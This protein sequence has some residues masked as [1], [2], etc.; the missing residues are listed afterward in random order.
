MPPGCPLVVTDNAS[1]DSTREILQAAPNTT[2]I[3]NEVGRGF[4]NAANQGLAQ[5]KDCDVV[6]LVNPDAKLRPDCL[7]RLLAAAERYPQAGVYRGTRPLESRSTADFGYAPFTVVRGETVSPT[8]SK[9]L[10]RAERLLLDAAE[11]PSDAEA[12]HA[13]GLFYLNEKQ[14]DKARPCADAIVWRP[15]RSIP[16]KVL[17]RMARSPLLIRWVPASSK[18]TLLP[19]RQRSRAG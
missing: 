19:G 11:N 8:D 9:A 2:L 17:R 3:R 15:K 14:L 16:K 10:D 12:H 18:P 6:L 1:R 5:A 4:G 7:E 13:L